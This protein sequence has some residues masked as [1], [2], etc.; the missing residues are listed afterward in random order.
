MDYEKI[1][2]YLRLMKKYD[3]AELEF[4]SDDNKL[5]VKRAGDNVQTFNPQLAQVA[6]TTVPLA[7]NGQVPALAVETVP[8]A[9]AEPVED[10]VLEENIVKSPVVGV[11]YSSPSPDEDA[12]VSVGDQVEEG[13]TVC[14]IEA[15]KLMNEVP[16]HKSGVIKEIL[17]ANGQKVEYGQHLIIIE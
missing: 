3:I 16:A 7:P 1:E 12:F 17:A 5:K 6:P 11:Y 2:E 14:I 9:P 8:E 15:M 13:D 4:E 10:E